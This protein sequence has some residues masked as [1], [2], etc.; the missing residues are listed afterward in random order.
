VTL[1]G[2]VASRTFNPESFTHRKLLLNEELSPAE[3][4]YRRLSSLQHAYRRHWGVGPDALHLAR[5]FAGVVQEKPE[6]EEA[7]G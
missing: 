1:T 3:P 7:S 2:L 4:N 6:A 5:V